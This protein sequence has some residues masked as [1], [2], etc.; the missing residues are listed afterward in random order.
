MATTLL[1]GILNGFLLQLHL[2]VVYI[3]S[4]DRKNDV[5]GAE[6]LTCI[7]CLVPPVDLLIVWAD[8]YDEKDLDKANVEVVGEAETVKPLH[9]LQVHVLKPC[10]EPINGHH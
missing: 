8:Q 6:D 1:S 4:D 5:D 7:S 10:F 2:T 9:R 3:S